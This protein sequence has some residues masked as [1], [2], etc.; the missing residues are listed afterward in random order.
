MLERIETILRDQCGLRKDAPIVVGVSGGPD[1]LC[2]LDLLC[3]AG[4]PVRVA[5]FNHGLRSEADADA[6]KVT[7]IAERLSVPFA[8]QRADVRKYAGAKGISLEA[9]ARE[10]RYSFLFAEA[11]SQNAQA[12]AVGHTADDQAETVLMHFI[13]G[14]GLRGLG[15]MAYRA[16]L[17]VFDPSIPLVRPLLGFWHRETEEYCASRGLSPLHDASNA[18]SDY[19]RNRVRNDLI[20]VLEKYNPRIREVLLRNAAAL[21][22]DQALLDEMLVGEWEQV[23]I[24]SSADFV[25]L[26]LTRTANCSPA[27]QRQLIR[28][29][30]ETLAPT[31]Q[32]DFAALDRGVSLVADPSARHADL[33]AGLSLYR[34]SELLYVAA[35]GAKLPS[36]AW[37]QMPP[38]VNIVEVSVPGHVE[39]AAGWRFEATRLPVEVSGT[40]LG[41]QTGDRFLAELDLAALPGSLQLRV[42]RPG[43]MVQPL[44]LGG[45]SQKLSDFFVNE[46]VPA[47]A[48]ARWPLLCAGETVVWV[49]GHRLAEPFKLEPKSREIARFCLKPPASG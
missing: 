39:L 5:H 34:E 32:I 36:E 28:R 21:S 29:A 44:G 49:P 11:R 43:D 37:P 38:G 13:R 20:P 12:V 31:E 1:S 18:S 10:L 45:H 23:L 4:Y 6:A 24:R 9:A 15:G 33:T 40:H 27:L 26:D 48:R 16:L 3:Q 47:R 30:V 2:L 22:S 8:A 42:R 17:R 35:A 46:K 7:K 41:F 25:A 14:T 19:F